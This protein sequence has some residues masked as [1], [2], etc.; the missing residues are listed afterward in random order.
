[1]GLGN[2]DA[3]T[4]YTADARLSGGAGF[5]GVT[6]ITGW[7]RIMG[8]TATAT[9]RGLPGLQVPSGFLKPLVSGDC[10][11][12]GTLGPGHCHCCW[13]PRVL[14]AASAASKVSDEGAATRG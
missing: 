9:T 14:C 3:C 13:G 4:A 10:A 11:V 2:T 12:P 7:A 6:T 8:D 1:M 5:V